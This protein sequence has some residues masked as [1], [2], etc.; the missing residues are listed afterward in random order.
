MRHVRA[1]FRLLLLVLSLLVGFP[2]WFLIHM[3]LFPLPNRQ[4]AWRNGCTRGCA[5][6]A[7]RVMGLRIRVTGIPPEPPFCLVANHL[8]YLDAI[9]LMSHI[10][11]VMIAK[12]EI[13]SWPVIGWLSRQ[14]GTVFINREMAR[15][16]V[17]VNAMIARIL[18]E[19]DGIAFFPEGTTTD[20]KQ[21]GRFNS[22]LLHYPAET[23]YPVHF[24]TIR[25]AT[26][27]VSAS[28]FVC[29]G[30]DIVFGPHLYRAAGIRSIRADVQFG[31]SP[32]KDSDRKRLTSRLR[33]EV[34]TAFLPVDL[35][36]LS[37][38][39]NPIPGQSGVWRFCETCLI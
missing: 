6:F 3:L 27:Q 17:R 5:R 29:W 31:K 28:E 26:K 34:A 4:R 19:G 14:I 39:T 12:S 38:I 13:A 16:V 2:I 36:A 11:G 30:S 20:G 21:V 24:A 35:I 15:D 9:T 1:I 37:C 22:S 8:S 10:H 33:E 23:G 32:L 7:A 25:Y 18:D